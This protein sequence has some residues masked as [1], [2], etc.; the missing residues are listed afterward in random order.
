MKI[1]LN[2]EE[3]LHLIAVALRDHYKLSCGCHVVG[4]KGPNNRNVKIEV[5]VAVPLR[6]Q[7]MPEEP[8]P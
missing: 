1:R 2:H 3:V 7:D 6:E 8:I 4:V 5:E